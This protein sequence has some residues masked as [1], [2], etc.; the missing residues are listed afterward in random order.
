MIR[1]YVV[2]SK[3][4][5]ILQFFFVLIRF[6]VLFS[7]YLCCKIPNKYYDYHVVHLSFPVVVKKTFGDSFQGPSKLEGPLLL[8]M[9]SP[10]LRELSRRSL[11]ISC[12]RSMRG[13]LVFP[14]WYPR[15]HKPGPYAVTEEERRV[16][17]IKYGLRPEDYKP[18]DKDDVVRYAGDYPDLGTVTYDHKD[19][20]EDWTDRLNRR[21]W[22]EMVPGF[23]SSSR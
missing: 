9:F 20:Y 8:G 14:G 6:Y 17:A 18:M 1:V 21:N 16:A 5:V 19:P 13:P 2:K 4:S 15:D 11:H 10:P 12:V 23:Y 22:G 7:F 3:Q